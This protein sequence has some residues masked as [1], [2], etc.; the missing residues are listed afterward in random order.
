MKNR[1][2][3]V[4]ISCLFL[5]TA[6]QDVSSSSNKEESVEALQLKELSGREK[7]YANIGNDYIAVYEVGEIPEEIATLEMIVHAYENGK[8][9]DDYENSVFAL[10]L[11]EQEDEELAEIVVGMTEQSSEEDKTTYRLELTQLFERHHEDSG[12]MNRTSSISNILLPF[13]MNH[14][15]SS[16][17][18]NVPIVVGETSWLL[19]QHSGSSSVHDVNRENNLEK[20]ISEE[21]RVIAI[22]VRWT[23][24][25][26]AEMV[27]DEVNSVAWKRGNKTNQSMVK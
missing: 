15:V 7:E 26:T 14:A 4:A 1:V 2:I 10:G 23:D 17:Q 27:M 22:G 8:R 18:S 13:E 21:E 9:V 11:V 20:L 25:E 19:V 3:L 5:F 6:C 24:K 12:E 16:V